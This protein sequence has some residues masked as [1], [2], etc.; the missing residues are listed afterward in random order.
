[1]KLF[2]CKD[3]LEL[4]I[5][6]STTQCQHPDSMISA[7]GP[8]SFARVPILHG[9]CGRTMTIKCCSSIVGKRRHQKEP[10]P[11]DNSQGIG[12]MARAKTYFDTREL[13]KYHK[14]PIMQLGDIQKTCMGYAKQQSRGAWGDIEE[15]RRDLQR[16]FICMMA[17]CSSILNVRGY[18]S[19]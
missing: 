14:A 5:C 8:N 16:F 10:V 9:E 11:K 1:M 15:T 4:V 19:L 7:W 6:S 18:V 3:V 12:S 17:A 13:L 2:K